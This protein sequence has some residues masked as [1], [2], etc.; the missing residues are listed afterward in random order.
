GGGGSDPNL[1]TNSGVLSRLTW[2]GSSWDKVDL[3]RGLPRCE[4]NHSTNGM[5]LS[6]NTLLVQSGGH[7]N[8]GAPSNNFAGTPEYFLSGV[9]LSIDLA[10]LNSMPVYTDPRSGVQY[11]YDLP[12]LND[13]SRPDI[14]KASPNFP[15]PVGHPMRDATIDEGDPFGG[16]NSLNQ[17]FAEAGG[18]VSIQSFGYRNAYDVVITQDG[19]IFTGDNGP[20]TGWGGQPIIYNANGTVKGVQGQN[21]VTF[22]PGAGDYITNDFN[23][24]QSNGHGDPLHYVGPL[25]SPN[26]SYYA[27][28]PKAIQAFPSRAKIIVYEKSGSNWIATQQYNLADL[29]G[30]VSGYFSSSYDIS[31]FPDRPTE[32]EYLA[33]NNQPNKINIIDIVNSSTNGMAEYTASNFNGALQGD[34]L[35]ASFNGKINRYKLAN[36][37]TTAIIDEVLFQGFGNT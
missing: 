5:A 6:G 29:L 17:A 35:T 7:T 30:N 13:P 8:K 34:L 15:Y 25:G 10:Q 3:V 19:H 12:T 20:N 18:P 4:E 28:H 36:D 37:K 24:S 32:G 1:D 14:T 21:G 23:E 2:N 31:D 16:N 9:L 33:D 27:G 22:N 11:V 26:G